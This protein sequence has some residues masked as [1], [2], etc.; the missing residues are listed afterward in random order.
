MVD[1]DFAGGDPV[2]DFWPWPR[3]RIHIINSSF[4]QDS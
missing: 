2:F 3:G 1:E 4:I